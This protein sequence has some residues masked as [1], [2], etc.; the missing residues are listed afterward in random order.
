MYILQVGFH[1]MLLQDD[2]CNFRV[3]YANLI[4]F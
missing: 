3:Y 4:L 2:T 1:V